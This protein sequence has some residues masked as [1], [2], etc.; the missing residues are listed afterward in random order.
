MIFNL[1]IEFVCF[2]SI[3]LIYINILQKLPTVYSNSAIYVHTTLHK[4]NSFLTG[5]IKFVPSN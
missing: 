2:V 5:K 1:L 3:R 4:Q